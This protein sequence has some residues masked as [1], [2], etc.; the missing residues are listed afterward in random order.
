MTSGVIRS[1]RSR[2]TEFEVMSRVGSRASSRGAGVCLD[3]R[4]PVVISPVAIVGPGNSNLGQ[5]PV[6]RQMHPCEAVAVGVGR[7]GR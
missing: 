4:A 3:T 2:Y 7:T 1:I 5:T 6:L